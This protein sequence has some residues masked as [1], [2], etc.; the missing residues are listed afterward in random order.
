MI[1]LF[2]ELVLAGFRQPLL[3]GVW[4]Y[5]AA[6]IL[7]IAAEST[8]TSRFKRLDYTYPQGA[9]IAGLSRRVRGPVVRWP[10]LIASRL[11]P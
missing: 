5:L 10:A 4:P 7:K 9:G 11:R 6:A 2:A 1:G 8:A 3:Q